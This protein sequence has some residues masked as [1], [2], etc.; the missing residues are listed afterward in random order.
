MD[1]IATGLVFTL[2][3]VEDIAEAVD[4]VTFHADPSASGAAPPPTPTPTPVSS[5][6]APTPAPVPDDP[7]LSKMDKAKGY[8]AKDTPKKI[9][10]SAELIAGQDRGKMYEKAQTRY[11]ER[12][13]KP[14]APDPDGSRTS[15]LFA[16]LKEVSGQ[17]KSFKHAAADTVFGWLEPFLSFLDTVPGVNILSGLVMSGKGAYD[18]YKRR[19]AF[20]EANTTASTNIKAKQDAS[21]TPTKADLEV[22]KSADYAYKK[23]NR[24]FWEGIGKF[25]TTVAK[26]ILRLITILTGGTSALVTETGALLIEIGQGALSLG[27]K[28]KGGIKR[29][30]GM[31]GRNRRLNATTVYNHAKA[32]D[33]VALKLVMDLKPYGTWA[34]IKAKLPGTTSPPSTPDQ[35]LAYLNAHAKGAEQKAL[36][37]EIA[38]KMKST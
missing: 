33:P 8:L 31:R 9:K 38:N 30:F 6:P 35:M 4:V 22:Q 2:V 10:G 29:L 36:I 34:S 16:P 18:S 15:A 25:V 12:P 26:Y 37:L 19:K 1:V 27:H 14:A 3:E 21:A 17:V 32:G 5:G 28:V 13:E 20:A 23:S 24:A 11:G 7:G